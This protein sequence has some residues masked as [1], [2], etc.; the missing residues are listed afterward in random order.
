MRV[1]LTFSAFA[2]NKCVSDVAA[3]TSTDGSFGAGA[4][5]SRGAFSV[6]TA[7]VWLAKVLGFERSAE[8]EGIASHSFGAGADR[9]QS[10]EVAVSVVTARVSARVYTRV[11]HASRLVAGAFAVRG[12]F[13]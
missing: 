10:A 11:V 9:G 13:S 8:C 7:W 2:R 12:A 4:V 1:E 5:V 6:G 3:G